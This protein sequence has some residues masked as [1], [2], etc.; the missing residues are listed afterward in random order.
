MKEKILMY[1]L[2]NG[3]IT[4]WEAMKELGCADLQHYIMELREEYIIIDEWVH[5]V[6]RWGDKIKYK[7]YYLGVDNEKGNR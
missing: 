7:K 3:S 4:T 2:E 1:L 5:G 6:N